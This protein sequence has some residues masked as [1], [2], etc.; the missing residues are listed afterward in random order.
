MRASLAT[1]ARLGH[2]PAGTGTS[3]GLSDGRDRTFAR[4]ITLLAMAILALV[5]IMATLHAPTDLSHGFLT[6]VVTLGLAPIGIQVL[7]KLVNRRKSNWLCVELVAM[8]FYCVVHFACIIYWLNGSNPYDQ[9]MW[10]SVRAGNSASHVC[11]TIAMC[12]AGIAMFGVG[13]NLL[14]DRFETAVRPQ[15][16]ESRDLNR[17]RVVGFRICL[18]TA[19]V[20]GTILGLQGPGAL[21]GGY[22][23]S[24]TESGL[25]NVLLR[26]NMVLTVAAAGCLAVASFRQRQKLTAMGLFPSL[27]LLAV[28]GGYAIHG[29]RNLPFNSLFVLAVAYSEQVRRISLWQCAVF[30]LLGML[31]GTLI[32]VARVS[33]QRTLSSMYNTV[34][35]N[36]DKIRADHAIVELGYSVQPLFASTAWVPEKHPYY[37]GSLMSLE[38]VNIIPFAFRV[39]LVQRLFAGTE[40]YETNSSKLLTWIIVGNFLSGGKGTSSV[41]DYYLNFGM[42]GVLGFLFLE[43]LLAKYIQQKARQSS[44]IIWGSMHAFMIPTIAYSARAGIVGVLVEGMI[45]PSLAMVLLRS[46]MQQSGKRRRTVLSGRSIAQ[47]VVSK[48]KLRVQL[49]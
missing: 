3:N 44:S 17:W 10:E 13:F 40:Y 6:F 15:P 22:K 38:A 8:S 1:S 28:I 29:D 4:L 46:L 19:L 5:S 35:V 31:G 45:W 27:L 47:R 21:E 26:M 18:G 25:V 39:P 42:I 41:A 7:Y 23:G 9:V 24:E 32:G 12:A 48:K 34:M 43:G 11:F 49:P 20:A 2:I 33:P 37:Y 36:S 14:P 30:V 16:Q